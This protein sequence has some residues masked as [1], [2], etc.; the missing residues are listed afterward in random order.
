LAVCPSHINIVMRILLIAFSRIFFC[1][2]THPNRFIS[3]FGI[4]RLVCFLTVVELA[5][6]RMV[7]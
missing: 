1:I 7:H 3:A 5:H 6:A 2:L 4:I